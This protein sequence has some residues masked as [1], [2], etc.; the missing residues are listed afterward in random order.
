MPPIPF[1]FCGS[2]RACVSACSAAHACGSTCSA[3]RTR[4]SCGSALSGV[5]FCFGASQPS[6]CSV[7]SRTCF[8]FPGGYGASS[9]VHEI[10]CVTSPTRSSFS[11]P[12]GTLTKSPARMLSS[13]VIYESSNRELLKRTLQYVY[14]CFACL[15]VFVAMVCPNASSHLYISAVRFRMKSRTSHSLQYNMLQCFS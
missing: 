1:F 6:G 13:S 11:L 8:V 3:T 9:L 4:V 2:K 14:C 10:T 5:F 7:F 15:S 12:N